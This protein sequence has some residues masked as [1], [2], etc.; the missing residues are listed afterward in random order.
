MA[1]KKL[2]TRE[3]Y[4]KIMTELRSGNV[5]PVYLL[6][7]EEAYYI[8][9]V[10]GY[11]TANLLSEE[12]KD[13]NLTTVY[14]PDT[15]ARDVINY[16]SRYPIMAA[17]QIVVVREA[18]KLKDIDLLEKYMDKPVKTTV[19]V[20]CHMG[21]PLDGRKKVTAKAA[22][23]GRVL[24][25]ESPRYDR[26]I[27]AFITD[28]VRRPEYNATID[29]RTAAIIAANIGGDLKRLTSELDKL[30]I[31]FTPGAP[32]NITNELIEQ[33]IGI[34]KQYNIFELRDALVNKD[35]LKANRIMKYFED[36]PRAAAAPQILSLLFNYFRDLMLCYYAPRP[37]NES[38]IMSQL[39]LTRAWFAKD[40]MTGM[41]NYPARKTI[42]IISKIRETDARIKGI[43][44]VSTSQGDLMKELIA[45]ILH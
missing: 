33:H 27:V 39:N 43:D 10:T 45:F 29:A 6:M 5:A 2:T 41:R 36:N 12:E 28:Y 24:V 19:L 13:F 4:D 22:S 32:R 37:I 16:A 44:N 38:A 21:K 20:L 42:T 17:R 25:S 11:I 18:Q 35:P 15:T 8:D 40:F 3:A 23:V 14:G 31:A 9:Q 1:E 30:L 34:S 26:D 7:G